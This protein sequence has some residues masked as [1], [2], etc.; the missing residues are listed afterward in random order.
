MSKK[1]ILVLCDFFLPGFKAGGPIRTLAN[2]VELLSDTF[3]FKI[4]TLDRDC[5][6]KTPYPEILRG[7]WNKC[8]K[9]QVYYLTPSNVLRDLQ[10]IISI[11]HHDLLYLNSFFSPKFTINP[12]ILR[13]LKLIPQTPV[14][15]AP[16]GEFSQGALTIKKYKKNLY[17]KL[18]K[19]FRIYKNVIWQASSIHEKE[20]IIRSYQLIGKDQ[21]KSSIIVAPDLTPMVVDIKYEKQKKDKGRINI[22]FISRISSKKNLENALKMLESIKGEIFFNIYG[23]IEDQNYWQCCR[24]IINNLSSNIIVKYHGAVNHDKIFEILAQHDLFLFPTYGENFGHV[25]LEAFLAGCPVLISDQTPWRGLE[26]E[27]AGWDLPL[28][29]PDR[30]REILC[31]CVEMDADE[32]GK[33]SSGAR[34][35]GLK[36]SS[37]PELVNS[38][39]ELFLKVL[40][41]ISKQ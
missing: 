26:E 24:E 2:M 32:M 12:L 17:I 33:W 22:C 11:T 39:R 30:F 19:F 35:Y 23:P 36:Y 3:I 4:I 16:R 8:G 10:K 7:V 40:S 27:A 1:T 5:G 6:D 25:I 18:S 38:N 29:Q 20:D 9:A 41:G 37:N 31:R 14:V 28:S 21:L 34:S 15:L 13:S